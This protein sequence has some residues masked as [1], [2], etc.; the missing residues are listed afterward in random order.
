MISV[1]AG[2][3]RILSKLAP[4]PAEIV[5]LSQAW[6]RV[7]AASVDARLTQPPDDVSAMDGYALR[8]ADASA[9]AVLRVIG[10]APAGHP[11]AGTVQAGQA[12]RLFTGS[13]VPQ[14]ADT[15]LLQEDATRD[16]E[17][18]TVT[19]LRRSGGIS[20]GAARILPWAKRCCGPAR[21]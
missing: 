2:R 20:A 8:A 18:V 11:F 10:E 19:R 12:V 3:A 1:E 4:L 17:T 16:G 13:V 15:V 7:L 6:H 14:G 21:G 5:A 9:G